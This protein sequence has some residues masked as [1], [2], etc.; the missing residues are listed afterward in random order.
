MSKK[1]QKLTKLDEFKTYRNFGM[2]SLLAL[3]A[4]IFTQ[5]KVIDTWILLFTLFAILGLGITIF[6]L[7]VKILKIINELGDL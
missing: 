6:I 4:F 2:T 5:Y 1:D 7:Q 3:I